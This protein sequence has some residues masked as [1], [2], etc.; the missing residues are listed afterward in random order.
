[1]ANKRKQY[2]PQ[3]KAKV[4]LEAIRGDKTVPELASQYRC[5]DSNGKILFVKGC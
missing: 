3:L 1:M 5:W 2:S 4:A